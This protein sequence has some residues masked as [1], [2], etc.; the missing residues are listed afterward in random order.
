M[1]PNVTQALAEVLVF[2]RHRQP[3]DKAPEARFFGS[4]FE[5][6]I[7]QPDSSVFYAHS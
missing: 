2:C 7:V 4:A 5:T 1:K 6:L 3:L